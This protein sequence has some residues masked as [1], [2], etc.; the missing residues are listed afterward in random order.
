MS[1]FGQPRRGPD[2]VLG[3]E[4]DDED[5]GVVGRPAGHD[6]PGGGVERRDEFLPEDDP[7]LGE[8]AVREVDRLGRGPAE[9]HVEL[10][11]PEDEAVVLVDDRDLGLAAEPLGEARG[12]LESAESGAYDHDLHGAL[13]SGPLPYYAR[14]SSWPGRLI[15][16]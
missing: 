12:D 3:A 4:H 15:C 7:P 9:H 10:R 11:V 1:A 5:V 14:G 16:E 6:A 8:G 13:P 2:I